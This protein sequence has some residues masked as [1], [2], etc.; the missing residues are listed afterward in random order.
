MVLLLER[1]FYIPNVT[2]PKAIELRQ[3][4]VRQSVLATQRRVLNAEALPAG[5]AGSNF[6]KRGYASSSAFLG[7]I[8][9]LIQC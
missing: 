7:E 2:S 5:I 6:C 8:L 1:R 4:S 3:P 9:A